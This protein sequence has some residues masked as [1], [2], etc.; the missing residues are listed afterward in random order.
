V[1]HVTE[2]DIQQLV[3]GRLGAEERRR[4]IRHLLSSCPECLAKLA[5]FAVALEEEREPADPADPADIV[6]LTA[7]DEAVWDGVFDRALSAA[8]RRAERAWEERAW[9]DRFLAD[10][11]SRGLG[12]DGIVD[13]IDEDM[14]GRA[15]VE[16]LLALSFEARYRSPREMLLLA[17][18]A[19]VAAVNLGKDKE[20]GVYSAAELADLRAQAWAE[21][22]NAHRVCE[23]LEAADAAVAIAAAWQSR[24]SGDLSLLA[25]ILDVRASIRT[26]ERRLDEASSLLDR[27]H[28][29]YLQI[30]E[31]HLAGRAL[32]KKGISIH[33]DDRAAEAI[34]VLRRGLSLIDSRGDLQLFATGYQCLL[35]AMVSNGDFRAARRLLFESGLRLSFADE[36]LNLLKLDWLEGR[37]LAGLGNLALA[38][39]TLAAVHDGFLDVGLDYEAALVGLERAAVLLQLGRSAEVEELAAEALATFRALD[40]SREAWR[41]VRFLQEALQQRVATADL[42]RQVLGFLQR[43]ERK[44]Y[45]RFAP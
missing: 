17:V 42:V 21:L 31:T 19:Q 2:A 44:P 25:R 9:R 37:I 45:L 22:A 26:D 20:Q 10:V 23:D 18:G 39:K 7:A 3:A 41:A 40:V 33:Y 5:V 32:V 13:A 29:L 43:L 1:S 35:D 27:V 14:P 16:A 8:T 34:P 28:D 24:G 38:E 4:A 36:P 6:V 15:R 30:G 12:F 11:R